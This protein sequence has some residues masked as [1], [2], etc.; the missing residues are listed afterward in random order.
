MYGHGSN[1]KAIFKLS[2]IKNKEDIERVTCFLAMNAKD[3]GKRC[4]EPISA[5]IIREII[6]K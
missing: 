3:Y 6:K 5:R 4:V 1:I 2:K